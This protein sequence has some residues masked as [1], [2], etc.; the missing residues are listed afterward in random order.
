MLLLQLVV[1]ALR[2][3]LRVVATIRVHV[4]KR[5]VL[6]DVLQWRK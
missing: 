5:A 4:P 2:K 1:D 6:D 3:Q